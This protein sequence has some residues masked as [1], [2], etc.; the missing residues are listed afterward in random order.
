M[1]SGHEGEKPVDT[2]T[3]PDC[4]SESRDPEWCD[5]CGAPMASSKDTAVRW[6]EPGQTISIEI[7]GNA[8]EMT[9]REVIENYA[10]RRV[11][12]ADVDANRALIL[13]ERET[14]GGKLPE[15]SPELAKL[16]RHPVAH[17]T[18][19]EHPLRVYEDSPGVTIEDLVDVSNGQLSFAQVKDT[20]LAVVDLV[21]EAHRQQQLVLA[22]APWT[23]RIE[24]G[25]LSKRASRSAYSPQTELETVDVG[26]EDFAEPPGGPEQRREDV[27]LEEPLSAVLAAGKRQVGYDSELSEPSDAD[28]GGPRPTDKVHTREMSPEEVDAAVADADSEIEELSESSDLSEVSGEVEELLNALDSEAVETA[29]GEV[30]ILDDE[31]MSDWNMFDHDY[32]DDDE[33]DDEIVD[34]LEDTGILNID[35]LVEEDEPAHAVLDGLDRLYPFNETPDEVPVV[36]GFSPPELLGRVRADLAPWCDVFSLGMLLYYMVSGHI[37]PASVYTRYTPALPMRNFRPGF[38]PGLQPVVSRA[39]RPAPD[40]RYSSVEALRDAF[41]NACELMERRSSHIGSANPPRV[42][43]AVDTHVGINKGKRNPT[44]QDSVFGKVSDDGRFSLIVV[45]DGVSTAS[46][47]SGD[48]ASHQLTIAAA[49]IWEDVLPAYLMD[50]R[51]DEI[52]IIRDILNRA[53]DGIVKHV[54]EHHTPFMGNPHEVMGSTA[55]VCIIR[56]GVVT[57]A[58]LGDSRAYIQNAS[59]LEQT[60]IDHNLW[61]LSILDG[62]A[63]DSALAMPHGDALARCLGTFM[64]ENGNLD[65]VN[66]EPDFFRFALSRGDSLLLTTDGLVDFAGANPFAAEENV[67]AVMLAEPDPALACLELILLANRGGGGDNIGIG[68]AQ[69]I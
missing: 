24:G 47:G 19:G 4:G 17:A 21:I 9:V 12:V 69:F 11:V 20:F 39:T 10:T 61:T 43:V 15:L 40:D 1:A 38:P 31:T 29:E 8:T 30:E 5:T 55:L 23:V 68:I 13:E 59:G 58:S 60:T 32:D 67:L 36:M 3:C 64:I 62:V 66:P 57:L 37:P 7:E 49:A 63:P 14:F 18:H 26:R 65:P 2:F 35:A 44:N 41:L 50:E 25:A 33:D 6:L 16:F 34:V 22:V 52:G 27:T 53:N 46:Y 54:N 28:S 45:A 42:H 51:I 56:D 48:L